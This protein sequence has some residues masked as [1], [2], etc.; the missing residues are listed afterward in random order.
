[1]AQQ[2]S[3]QP[4]RRLHLSLC[5]ALS[6]LLSVLFVQAQTRA[7]AV[8]L[9][10]PSAIA[11][12]T[13][14]NL[15]IAETG[16]HL[17][18]KVDATGSITTVA[19]TG[20]QGFSGDNGPA[21]AASLDSPQ[22]L[23]LDR[24]NHLY[25]ADTHNHRI[26][27]VDLTTGLIT[28]I[29]G[30][31]AGYSGD[32]GPA[33]TATLN[34]PTALAV[35]ANNNLYL[36]DTQNH[37]IRKIAAATGLITTVAGTG[38]QGFS[39]DNGPAVTAAI[40]SPTGMAVN[41]AGDLYLA[42]TH[43][44][45]IRKI[46]A[47]TGLITT[48]AGTGLPGYSGDSSP[49]TAATLSLPHGLTADRAG[50]LYLADTAN[51]RIRRI[52]AITGIITTIAG[53]GTQTFSGD[54]GAATAAGLDSPRTAVISPSGLV[55]L[56][57]TANQRIRQLD[58]Q[59]TPAIHTIAGLAT[60]SADTLTLTA[61]SSLVYGTGQL[62]ASLSSAAT[63]PILFTLLDP[64]TTTVTTLG[65][66]PLNANTASFDLSN[67]PVGSY[68][69]IA[70]FAGDPTHSAAQSRPLT[71]NITPRPLTATPNPITLLY[72][73]PAPT[74]TGALTGLL[75]QDDNALTSI[76]TAPIT[77][78]SPTGTYPI[79]AT[80][81]GTA[82]KN[83]ALTSTPANLTINSAPTLTTLAFSAASIAPGTPLTLTTHIASTTTGNPTGAIT[84]LDGTSR[85]LTATL[86]ATDSTTFT[87]DT[88]APGTHTLTALYA[89][90]KNFISSTSSPALIT[91][92][93]PTSADFAFTPTGAAS[94]TIPSG[95]TANFNFTLQIQNATLAS[96]ITLSATGLPPFAT[97]SFNPPVLP[98]GTTPNNFTLTINTAPASSLLRASK[99]PSP[100]LAL[101][102]FP[103]T[104]I[105]LRL[106]PHKT[107]SG[108]ALAMLAVMLTLCSGCGS[109][110][111]TGDQATNPVSTYTIT[112]TGTAT[113]P[114]GSILQHSITIQLLVQSVTSISN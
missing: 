11:Y 62:T 91:V 61:A 97:A 27:R 59:P 87:I 33:T 107:R 89:G 73:Q 48:I 71:F 106:R 47:T 21:T 96:P 26:R 60:T 110:I 54:T 67:L 88:L 29:A 104:G 49:A 35:D 68:T 51:H 55:T 37:R 19:G 45:R 52:D 43:N 70:S 10:L 50:N 111:N 15:Y 83:Y 39:G 103:L 6:L 36:A 76:F 78:S 85:I 18:R 63:G 12:D 94:Q 16:N 31:T 53:T 108:I 23:A 77:A 64:T 4:S 2:S 46:A 86:P 24:N 32:N 90:D 72:G 20:T 30:A 3:L 102:L 38:T 114:T 113:G 14:G 44:H 92:I 105:V 8:P 13:Q 101:L 66:A 82:A 100:L 41:A 42:D 57:D 95:G 112:V 79:T 1:M 5:A 40:D 65:T 75:Q 93:P 56:A 28:T 22:G 25:L 17:I 74:L 99:K 109:R 34:L 84:V 7:T 98:P 81:T 69:L 58:A 9:L 80:I